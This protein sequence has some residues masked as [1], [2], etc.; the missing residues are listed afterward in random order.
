VS[1]THK[2][3]RGNVLVGEDEPSSCAL[4]SETEHLMES[5]GKQMMRKSTGTLYRI[6]VRSEL[7]DRYAVAF[8]GMEM[9]TRNGDTILTGEVIDQPQ[10]YGILD[11]IN[12]LGLQ[13][14]SVQALPEDAHALPEDAHSSPEGNR[15][16]E[17]P[18]L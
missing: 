13:L 5:G 14:L 3:P 15:E 7:S 17:E 16:P 18:E 4:R 2:S 9:E 1:Q 8:E 6:V 11:R 10:L 12:G